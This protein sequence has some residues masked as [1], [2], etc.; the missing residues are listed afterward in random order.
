M[1]STSSANHPIVGCPKP[2]ISAADGSVPLR[3]ELRDLQQDRDLFNLYILGLDMFCKIDQKNELSFYGVAGIH[4]RPYRVW[5]GVPGENP[6]GKWQGYCTHTSV[7]F[8][9]W[10]RPFLALYEQQIYDCVQKVAAQF[11]TE[12]RARYRECATRFRV[13]YWDWAKYPS[14]DE[15]YFP[16]IVGQESINVITPT[17]GGK[18]VSIPNPLYSTKFNPIEPGDFSV[19]VAANGSNVLYDQFPTTLR[20]PN[21]ASSPSATS[22]ETDV[23]DTFKSA[24]PGL[25]QN[26][27]ILLTDPNYKDFAAFSTHHLLPSTVEGSEASLE[28][29]HN[30]IHGFVGGHGGHMADLDYAAYDPAFWLH[31]CNVDRFFAM[32]C[33]INPGKYTFDL[34]DIQDN[35]TY[36][37][38]AGT[39]ENLSIGL[40]PFVDHSGQAYW[41]P[42]GVGSTEIFNY[43]YPETQR[44]KF[45]S[46]AEYQNSINA[47]IYHLYGGVSKDV[48]TDLTPVVTKPVAAAPATT[49]PAE[50]KHGGLLKGIAKGVTNVVG[51]VVDTATD[52]VKDVVGGVGEV[53]QDILVPITQPITYTDYITTIKTIKHGLNEGY[54]VHVFLGE[55]NEDP[56]TWHT[57]DALCGIFMVFGRNTTAG[58]PNETGCGKCKV[59]A[60]DGVSISGIVPLTA[61]LLGEI[62]KGN[63]AS[64]RKEDVIPYLT[65]NLHW[66]VTLANGTEYARED[67][68]GLT[69][70][71]NTTEVTIPV[72]GLPQRSGVYE[73]H[74]ECTAGRL[75]GAITPA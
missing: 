48:A 15:G 72:G 65:T 28:D 13:P 11:P 49:A 63:C 26:I 60:A 31:H 10:H 44:W 8:A 12:S 66:R 68:P 57:Q 55:F 29:I 74:P 9:P 64:M 2:A 23:F 45:K 47:T 3:L 25:Q 14:R 40:S 34:T 1:T 52:V 69:I 24:Y 37:I 54:R 33:A 4:G 19:V 35:G 62:K 56:S 73:A 58:D 42:S 7:L 32:W 59:D 50:K 70:S 20:H 71:V 22:T 16:V 39:R 41:T 51:D 27:N 61:Q 67:V 6:D 18:E 36:V 5:G 75:A 30:S 21:D 43:A 17:S 46:D 53:V 38:K